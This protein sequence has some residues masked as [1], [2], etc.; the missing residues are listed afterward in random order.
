[1]LHDTLTASKIQDVMAG[2]G[3]VGSI[4]LLTGVAV[5]EGTMVGER[6]GTCVKTDAYRR[7]D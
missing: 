6:P 2:S 5:T 1:M 4:T 7:Q 3:R